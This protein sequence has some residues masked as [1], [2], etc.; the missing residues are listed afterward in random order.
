MAELTGLAPDKSRHRTARHKAAQSVLDFIQNLDECPR[1]Q[2]Q[3]MDSVDS[4]YLNVDVNRSN[5]GRDIAMR[6]WARI[7]K[8]HL[9]CPVW[10]FTSDKD[11]SVTAD[12][13]DGV[14]CFFYKSALNHTKKFAAPDQWL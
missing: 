14:P 12:R 10:I 3:I 5:Q 9:K 1:D 8:D 7:I 4:Q 6:C 11:A 2:M 13:V